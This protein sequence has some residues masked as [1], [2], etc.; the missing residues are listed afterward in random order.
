[1]HASGYGE[2]ETRK[3]KALK[4]ENNADAMPGS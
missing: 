4:G 2:L 3:L 1:M